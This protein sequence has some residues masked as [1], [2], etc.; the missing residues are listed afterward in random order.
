M[1]DQTANVNEGKIS[2]NAPCPCGS[3]KKY[4]LCCGAKVVAEERE[5]AERESPFW[6]PKG[7]TVERDD[8]NHMGLHATPKWSMELEILEEN[9]SEDDADNVIQNL[10][11]PFFD[12]YC[13]LRYLDDDGDFDIAVLE[14]F[15]DVGY[16]PDESPSVMVGRYSQLWDM[17]KDKVAE[18]LENCCI[19]SCTCEVRKDMMFGGPILTVFDDEEMTVFHVARQDRFDPSDRYSSGVREEETDAPED[20]EVIS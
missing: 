2:R 9:T 11:R 10:L 17:L 12:R 8:A 16:P 14:S 13:D 20:A 1:A 4:K 5:A 6:T 3:G 7:V 18:C 19:G 15:S